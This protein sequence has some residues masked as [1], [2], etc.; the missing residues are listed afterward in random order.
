MTNVK[1]V[2]LRSG[3]VVTTLNSSVSLPVVPY[4]IRLLEAIAAALSIDVDSLK[5]EKEVVS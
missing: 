1:S 2:T 3:A 5:A 4:H